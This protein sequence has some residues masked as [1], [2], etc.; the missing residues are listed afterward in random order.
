MAATLAIILAKALGNYTATFKA[1]SGEEYTVKY[2]IIENHGIHKLTIEWT[3]SSSKFIKMKFYHEGHSKSLFKTCMAVTNKN[4]AST[5]ITNT[6]HKGMCTI[7]IFP[8]ADNSKCTAPTRPVTK[9][10]E[11]ILK[12]KLEQLSIDMNNLIQTGC[13]SDVVITD[14]RLMQI[15]AHKIVLSARSSVFAKMFEHPMKENQENVVTIED[16]APEVLKELLHF[17]YS[18]RILIKDWKMARDLY[19]AADKYNIKDLREICSGMLKSVDLN[20][21]LDLLIL[22]DMHSDE[23]LRKV[24]LNFAS[25]CYSQLKKLPKWNIFMKE[26]QPLAIEI[27]SSVIDNK[28]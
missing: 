20:N 11:P 15:R 1:F 13:L 5:V 16:I 14:G 27:L 9:Q 10:L 26:Y 22:A 23:I 4:H 12:N 28:M 19:V 3:E 2:N 24:A 18:G 6:I 7:A 17:I 8:L 25:V 21:V